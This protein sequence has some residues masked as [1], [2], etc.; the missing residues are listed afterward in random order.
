VK[1]FTFKITYNANSVV[2]TNVPSLNGAPGTGSLSPNARYVNELYHELLHRDAEPAALS[3]GA[4]LLDAGVSREVVA[5]G[6]YDSAEHRGIQVDEYYQ[7]YLHRAADPQGRAAG[8]SAL[9]AGVSETALQA[10]FLASPEYMQQHAGP[11]AFVNGVYTDVLG[12]A[13]DAV[14]LVHWANVAASPGGPGAVALAILNSTE[15]DVDLIWHDYE[16]SLGRGPDA[17]SANTWLAILARHL[18]SPEQL[19]VALLTSN[20]FFARG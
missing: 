2:L 9:L 20:E 17:A 19:E 1:G 16:E 14:G 11:A 5:R 7:H 3:F 10:G 8:L 15:A 18:A 4:G 13:A 12:R 6:V